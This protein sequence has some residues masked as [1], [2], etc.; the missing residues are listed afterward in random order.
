MT[1]D[2]TVS[3]QSAYATAYRAARS[4]E[5]AV[6]AVRA[7]VDAVAQAGV[8]GVDRERFLD[9]IDW[10]KERLQ[11]SDERVPL[12]EVLRIAEL[13]MEVT[14][15]PALGLHWAERLTP[16]SF[17]PV[18][19]LLGHIHCLRHGLDLLVKFQPLFAD[20]PI[21]SLRETEDKAIIQ[22]NDWPCQSL[23]M[24]RFAA[25]IIVAGM[26]RMIHAV[27]QGAS[28]LRTLFEY[29]PPGYVSE[30]SRVLSAE[31][32]FDQPFSGIVFERALLDAALPHVDQDVYRALKGV[33]ECRLK[34]VSERAP[35]TLG[36]R[37]LMLRRMPRRTSMQAAARTLGISER[38]LRRQLIA[39]GTS[40]RD[41]EYLALGSVAK[42]MLRERKCSIQEVAYELGYA[43]TATF[44]RAFKRW[45]GSTPSEFRSAAD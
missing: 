2:A 43:D 20:Q 42:W 13:A 22:I 21:Y 36:L 15:D 6:L 8:V 7:L 18:S 25:E 41:V 32:R 29:A 28:V 30:Y 26:T 38:S 9:R 16:S 31:V 4:P 12:S 1:P 3:M 27:C 45:T 24:R 35:Y 11:L 33:A 37:E 10:T 19:H 23:Q 40:F 14:S 17:A 44:H 34:G 39:E 5:V